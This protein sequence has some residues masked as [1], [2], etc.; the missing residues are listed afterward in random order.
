MSASH[1]PANANPDTLE[2]NLD[3]QIE[4]PS[5]CKK[6]PLVMK[7]YGA[8]CLIDGIITAPI[9]GLFMLV[10]GWALIADPAELSVNIDPTLTVI[11]FSIGIA[12]AVA[13]AVALVVFGISL[14]R[15]HRR[16]AALISH[17]LIATTIAEMLVL[18]M[19]QGIGG[20]L[21]R[22]GIQLAILVALSVTV[23]PSLNQERELQRQLRDLEDREAAEKGMLGRD[24][25][26]KGFIELNFFNLFWVFVVCCFLG[27]IIETI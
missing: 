22:P 10:W 21:I 24:L 3:P 11:T 20:E 12:I 25:E 1:Q 5:E 18:I 26:G 4:T 23:D 13:N 14:L 17:V 2:N 9:L 6:I 8:L 19:L 7:I 15:N 27:L 16:H